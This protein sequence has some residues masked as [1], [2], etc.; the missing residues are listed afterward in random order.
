MM[1]IIMMIM[2]PSYYQRALCVVLVVDRVVA[3][4]LFRLEHV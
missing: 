1:M 3:L 4:A 2:C